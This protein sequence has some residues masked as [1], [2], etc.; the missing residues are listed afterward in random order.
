MAPFAVGSAR[1]GGLVSGE[2]R[3]NYMDLYDDWL[4]RRHFD[5]RDFAIAKS[6]RDTADISALRVE[7]QQWTEEVFPDTLR[8]CLIM[9]T[10]SSSPAGTCH[11]QQR[12]VHHHSVSHTLG[13]TIRASRRREFRFCFL[14]MAQKNIFMF[15]N[16]L[17]RVS[18]FHSVIDLWKIFTLFYNI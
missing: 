18:A 12:K 7:V 11:L 4:S 9:S 6:H 2:L 1:G 5:F 8:R 10:N 16:S 14:M 13:R 3:P 15:R 17:R